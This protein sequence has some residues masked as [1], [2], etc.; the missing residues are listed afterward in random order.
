M[1]RILDREIEW[2]TAR[3]EMQQT[4]DDKKEVYG[5]LAA[6]VPPQDAM[7]RLVR[8][9]AH[10]GREFDRIL[11]QLERVQR[12]RRGQPAPPT[13]NVNVST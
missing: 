5:R 3:E 11:N 6:L 1:M 7:D 9:E 4:Q 2:L 8:Y 12:M 10:L 13:L